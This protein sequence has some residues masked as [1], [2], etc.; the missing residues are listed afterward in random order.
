VP[1][2]PIDRT[3][4]CVRCGEDFNPKDLDA[5][6]YHESD[7][8]PRLATGI[9]GEP[10]DPQHPRRKTLQETVENVIE[11]KNAFLREV[12][13]TL[14]I[15]RLLNRLFPPDPPMPSKDPKRCKWCNDPIQFHYVGTRMCDRCWELDRRISRDLPLAARILA[16]YHGMQTHGKRSNH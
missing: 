14:R 4:R 9:Q 2:F 16:H 11:A 5:V 6:L 10:Y 7:H 12:A 13:K 3:I 15:D 1:R 8:L